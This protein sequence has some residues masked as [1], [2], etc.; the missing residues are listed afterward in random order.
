MAIDNTS[1]DSDSV[2]EIIGVGKWFG[3]SHVLKDI[4]LCIGQGEV[5]CIVG[6]SGAGKSTL[7]RTINHLEP[8]DEGE[9]LVNNHRVGYRER[10]GELVAVNEANAANS[11]RDI[12]MVFQDFALFWHMTL[13]ENVTLGP[14]A[15]L[16]LTKQEAEK[17]ARKLLERVGLEEK[18]AA[19]PR[20]LSGG[21][22][23]RGAIARA[24][25]MRPSLML[26]DEPT[27]ALDPD[28]SREVFATVE[29]LAREGMTMIIVSH[30]MAFVQ[31]VAS[32]IVMMSDGCIIRDINATDT[33]E[34]S[35]DDPIRAYLQ[36]IS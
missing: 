8:I 27:S 28:M 22:Q 7:L 11:R 26:F 31:Y 21:Q 6:S 20:S 29:D 19:Y 2:V 24:L 4:N 25:A 3:A 17:R 32:R 23:Q 5:V 1:S 34:L 12:G 30:E 14:R 35:K 15:V 33:A 16:G 36:S 13:L 9:I 10:N 18:F